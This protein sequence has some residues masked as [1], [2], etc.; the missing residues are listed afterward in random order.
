MNFNYENYIFLIFLIFLSSCGKHLEKGII[1]NK[2]YE[3]SKDH[4]YL[5]PMPSYSGKTTT[6]IMIPY[7]VHDNEDFLIQVEGIKKGDST[8]SKEWIYVSKKCYNSSY[9]GDT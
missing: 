2:Q 8:K 5:M 4:I 3:P 6:I 9:I 1:V 7:L